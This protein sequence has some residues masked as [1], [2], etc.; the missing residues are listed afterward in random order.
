ML[1]GESKIQPPPRALN[2]GP[3]KYPLMKQK[4]WL[5]ARSNC[6]VIALP[7]KNCLLKNLEKTRLGK[8]GTHPKTYVAAQKINQNNKNQKRVA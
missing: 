8:K 7:L 3:A 2:R 1:E 4:R 5:T 6:L